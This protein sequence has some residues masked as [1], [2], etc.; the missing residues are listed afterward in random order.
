LVWYGH[1]GRIRP[2]TEPSGRSR[3]PRPH[4]VRERPDAARPE[5]HIDR[6]PYSNW[7][8]SDATAIV[9]GCQQVVSS[10]PALALC[11]CG[12]IL[13]AA[14]SSSWGAEAILTDNGRSSP[15]RTRPRPRAR[16]RV[17]QDAAGRVVRPA[18][19]RLARWGADGAGRLGRAPQHD[20]AAPGRRRP[21]SSRPVRARPTSPSRACPGGHHGAGQLAT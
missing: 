17:A 5:P 19:V 18:R 3:H 9:A 13:D 21:A 8:S 2:E 10:D 16:W 15:R 12:L 11:G 14:A 20:A 7:C 1:G 4:L 6:S